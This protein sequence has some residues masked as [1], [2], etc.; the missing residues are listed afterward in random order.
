MKHELSLEFF[1]TDTNLAG[2]QVFLGKVFVK[3]HYSNPNCRIDYGEAIL[4]SKN[5][6]G[7]I[8]LS[9]GQCD[10]NRQRMV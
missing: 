5:P 1:L 4:D 8:T 10:M 7:G 6:T 9:H 2:S 3:G